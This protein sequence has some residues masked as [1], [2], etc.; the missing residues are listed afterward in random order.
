[1][2]SPTR[3]CAHLNLRRQR[4]AAAGLSG[5]S[6]SVARTAFFNITAAVSAGAAGVIIARSLGPSFRGEYA[7]IVAWFGV[8]FMIGDLG[9]TAATTFFVARGSPRQPDYVATSRNLMIVSGTTVLTVGA[10]AAPLLAPANPTVAWGYR[11]AFM[12]CLATLVG[13]SYT[14]AL[15]A[16]NI[17]RW[18]LVRI[19][20]PALFVAVVTILH[21]T[22]HLGLTTALVTMSITTVAQTALAYLL[23]RGQRLTGG[24]AAFALGRPMSRYGLGQLAASAPTLV[25]ARLDQLVLSL[26]VA[27]AVLGHY[28]VA[29]SLTTLA[30]PLV[31]AVG[32]VAFPRLA[33]QVLSRSGTD[34]LQRWSILASAGAGVALMI[35]LAGSASWLVPAAF[36]P[37]FRDAVPLIWLL[38]PGGVF[39]ACG[40]VCADLLRGHGRVLAVARAQ[41]VAAVTMILLLAVLLP[42]LGAAGAAIASSTAAGVALLIMLRTLRRPSAKTLATDSANIPPALRPAA[43]DPA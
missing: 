30:V 12:T 19:S 21:L 18:N 28:A 25:T 15:Q 7:A 2:T 17:A 14:S 20:Q 35:A 16:T 10:L 4:P 34:R 6:R 11:L 39:V 8:A 33:S 41:G 26:T 31:S 40:Q 22:G 9:Q 27:P 42:V 5:F 1:M 32:H 23:C 3:V 37:G 29:V 13:F 38:A 24:R 36:G 43:P